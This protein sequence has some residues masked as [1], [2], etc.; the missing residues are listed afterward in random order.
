MPTVF[1]S[2]SHDTPDHMSKAITLANRLRE[3]GVDASIDAYVPHPAEGWPKWMEK[4]FQLDFLIVILSPR[5]IKEFNQEQDTSSGVRFEAS[6][7]SSLLLSR[8]VSFENI[9]IVCFEDSIKLDIPP[10][11]YGCTRY[12]VEKKGEYD[13]LYAFLTKQ[14]LVEKPALG[15]VKKLSPVAP[16]AWPAEARTF[17]SLCVMLWPLMED[18]RRIFQDFG[19]NSGAVLFDAG[20]KEVR[21][22][23]SLW[24][25]YRKTIAENNTLIARYLRLYADVIPA[26]HGVLFR[27]W[28]SHIDAFARHLEDPTVDY[29]E[30]QFPRTVVGVVRE[31]L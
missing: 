21:H 12:H 26:T 10:V 3:Q 31:Q 6:I 29:R 14:V 28:L 30:H 9:A 27:K 2:Y 25:H 19:P 24:Q 15:S 16:A 13:K 22:D 18:N 20:E 5:Y 8:G 23:L 17:R 7:L 4:Q 11:L 1:I